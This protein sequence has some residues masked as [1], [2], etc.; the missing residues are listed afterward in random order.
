MRVN[1]HTCIFWPCKLDLNGSIWSNFTDG[2]VSIAHNFNKCVCGGGGH[3]GFR[4]SVYQGIHASIEENFQAMFLK[5]HFYN[6]P[7]TV[8]EQYFFLS[9]L[10]PIEELCPL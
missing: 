6:P 4:L 3:F 1:I 5:F 2:C 10:P 7:G 8:V 9:E